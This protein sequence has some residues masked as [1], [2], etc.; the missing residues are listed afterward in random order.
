MS[1]PLEQLP[2]ELKQQVMQYLDDDD[3]R[4]LGNTSTTMLAS[5]WEY[6]QPQL[7]AMQQQLQQMMDQIEQI[8]GWVPQFF[9]NN[10]GS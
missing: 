2:E 10:N 1:S 8:N 7:N 6:L 5:V 9:N 3:L 4:N